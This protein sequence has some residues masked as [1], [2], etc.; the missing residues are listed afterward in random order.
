MDFLQDLLQAGADPLIVDRNG[1]HSIHVAT[2]HG[3]PDILR[4]LLRSKQCRG[5]EFD[6]VNHAGENFLLSYNFKWISQAI[7]SRL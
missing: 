4:R 7:T 2:R 6:I 1:N 3:N 5:R